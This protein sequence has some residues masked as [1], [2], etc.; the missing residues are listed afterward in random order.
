[1]IFTT[2]HFTLPVLEVISRLGSDLAL[3]LEIIV[4]RP[5]PYSL[6]LNPTREI[7]PLVPLEIGDFLQQSGL[8]ASILV[9]LCRTK[10]AEVP[11]SLR[12]HS[13]V[14]IGGRRRW[15][16]S[17]EEQLERLCRARGHEVVFVEAGRRHLRKRK[18]PALDEPLNELRRLMKS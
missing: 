7:A 6:P 18:V 9:M 12:Q 11:Q 14:L 8:E 5:L 17:S 15:Y 4:P 3:A 10:Y 2:V 1:M 16:L 13:T